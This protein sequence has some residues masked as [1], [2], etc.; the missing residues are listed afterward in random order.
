MSLDTILAVIGRWIVAFFGRRQAVVV[1]DAAA[2]ARNREA[3]HDAHEAQA[4]A[5]VSRSVLADGV[6]D[7]S[8]F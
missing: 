6:R 5:P 1:Q 3:A 7:G 2:I 4:D 8:E